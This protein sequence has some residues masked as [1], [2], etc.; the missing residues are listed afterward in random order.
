MTCTID[1]ALGT[2]RLMGASRHSCDQLS[3]TDASMLER[4]LTG[5]KLKNILKA[6]EINKDKGVNVYAKMIEECAGSDK[7]ESLQSYDNKTISEIVVYILETYF[8]GDLEA[9]A[10]EKP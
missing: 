4:C 5:L 2:W 7:I 8:P 3:G 9:I 10:Q 1:N 6:G